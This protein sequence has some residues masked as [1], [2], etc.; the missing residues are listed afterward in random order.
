MPSLLDP[1]GRRHH[2][3]QRLAEPAD[4]A[5][6]HGCADRLVQV[7]QR[8]RHGRG[9]HWR[10]GESVSLALRLDEAAPRSAGVT[11]GSMS[12]DPKSATGLIVQQV[13]AVVPQ[14]DKETAG[15]DL[16]KALKNVGSIARDL[17]DLLAGVASVPS[18]RR[19]HGARAREVQ[20]DTR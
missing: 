12:E 13:A 7:G 18:D 8:H 6:Q 4:H 10:A 17:S 16:G 9:H 5:D 20:T 11:F 15:R 2:R 1:R 19:I 3:R 14:S